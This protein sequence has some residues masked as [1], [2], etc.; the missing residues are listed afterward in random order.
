MPSAIE[1]ELMKCDQR[2]GPPVPKLMPPQP[3]RGQWVG[4]SN[5]GKTFHCLSML[6]DP[7]MGMK[8]WD[9]I[10][11][12]APS[13]SLQ[14]PKLKV[15]KDKW[16]QF[17]HFIP[18]DLTI[19]KQEI[20]QR[21]S[22]ASAKGWLSLVVADDCQN[23]DKKERKF[24]EGLACHGRH[25]GVSVIEIC[26]TIFNGNK[27]SRLQASVLCLFNTHV[28][29]VRRMAEQICSSKQKADMLVQAFI[30]IIE[31]NPRGCLILDLAGRSTKD[32]WPCRARDTKWNCFIP[33]LMSL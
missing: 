8:T 17:V 25:Q 14:Q 26:Q 18:C 10:Y 19:P 21:L 7:D 30:K 27:T 29:E 23:L 16:K 5:A 33:A 1:K 2:K 22:E 15:L 24:L 11:W 28:G 12:L 20:E 6:C 31:T 32:S 4:Q 9:E 13:K 3:M